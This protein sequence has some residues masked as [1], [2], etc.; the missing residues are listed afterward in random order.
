MSTVTELLPPPPQP[1]A[2]PSQRLAPVARLRAIAGDSLYRNS[3]M[4]MANTAAS[5]ILGAVFWLVAARRFTTAEVGI[6]LATLSTTMLLGTAS[7]LGLPNSVVRF[8]PRRPETSGQLTVTAAVLTSVTSAVLF[9]VAAGTPWA[10]PLLR[11]HPS[12][13]LVLLGL[14]VVVLTSAAMTMDSTFIAQRSAHLLLVKNI[15]GGVVKVVAVALLPGTGLVTLASAILLGIVVSGVVTLA[16]MARRLS[17]PLGFSMASLSGVWSFSLGNHA[18]MICGILPI[19]ATPLIVLSS[20]GADKAAFFGV[21]MMLMGMLTVI[22]STFSQSLFAE[23]SVAPDTRKRQIRRAARATYLLLLPAVAVVLVAAR[24]LLRAF[25]RSYAAGGTACLRW[26]ALGALVAGTNYLVDVIVNSRGHAGSYLFLNASNAFLVLACTA[27]AAPYG[28]AAVGVGWLVAQ[29]LSVVVALGYLLASRPIAVTTAGAAIDGGRGGARWT[30]NA[31]SGTIDLTDPPVPAPAPPRGRRLHFLDGLR[32]LAAAF[33][34]VSHSWSTVFPEGRTQRTRVEV[35]TSWMGLGHYA[36]SVFIVISGFSLGLVAWRNDLHWPGGMRAFFK[37]RFRRI[38]PAYWAAIA[39]GAGLGATLL[40]HKD[41]TLWDGAVPIRL[42]GVITHALLLQ[43]VHWAG[44]A[45]STA[46]WSLAV[47]WHIYL[48]FPL[49]LVFL[50][51]RPEAWLA[52]FVLFGGIAAYS[53]LATSTAFTRWLQN[54]HPSLYALFV[55]GLVAARAAGQTEQ[56]LARRRRERGLMVAT[57][58]GLVAAAAS[59]RHFDPVG[60]I[61]D[62]WFGPA[63]ALGIGRLSTGSWPSARRLLEWRPLVL[64]G[65]C[66]Y[67][68]YLIHS[69]IIESVWRVAVKPLGLQGFSALSAEVV[70]GLAASV[71]AAAA[72]YW[73]VERHFLSSGARTAIAPITDAPLPVQR[74][75]RTVEEPVPGPGSLGHAYAKR[76]NSLN[77]LRVFFAFLVIVG[78][79]GH[80]GFNRLGPHLG[81]MY[82]ADVAVDGFFVISGFL[83][84][85]SRLRSRSGASYL[86]KRA[87]R[88]LPGYWACLVVTAFGLAPLLYWRIHGTFAGFMAAGN[89]PASYVTHN[90]ILVQAQT[91]VAGVLPHAMVPYVLNGSLWTL[92]YECLAYLGLAALASVGL[93]RSR[94]RLLPVITVLCLVGLAWLTVDPAGFKATLHSPELLPRS[95]RLGAVFCAGASLRLW[96]DRVPVSGRIAALCAVVVVASSALTDWQI[97]GAVPF[98]YLVLWL[99]T[100]LRR[101]HAVGSRHDLSYGIYLYAWPI[102]QTLTSVGGARLGFGGYIAVTTAVAAGCAWLSWRFIEA[103]AIRL[104]SLR[105]RGHATPPLP[106]GEVAQ[107]WFRYAPALDGL[108]AVAIGCVLLTHAGV[109]RLLGASQGVTVF[110]VVSG[111]L[112]TSLLLFEHDKTGRIDRGAFYRRRFARLLPVF[113]LSLLV[114]AAYLLADGYSIGKIWGPTVASLAY[115]ANFFYAAGHFGA[116]PGNTFFR[117]IWSLSIEEQ[118]Y[119]V[120]PTAVVLALKTR[121]AERILASVAGIVAI[122]ALVERRLLVRSSYARINYSTDTRIDAIML[123][124]LL[125]IALRRPAVRAAIARRADLL[126]AAGALVLA[127]VVVQGAV[128][129]ADPGGY[130]AAAL[131]SALLVAALV[132]RP[133]GS[134]HRFFACRPLVH[135]GRLSY[136]MYLW[137]VLLLEVFVRVVGEKPAFTPLG[138]VWL[139]ATWALSWASYRWVEKP[140]RQRFRAR[141]PPVPEPTQH[142]APELVSQ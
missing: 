59:Y 104:K 24:L 68:L 116:E 11:G 49:L 137:N 52:P 108:R 89:P 32:G 131:A 35:L 79:S 72:F 17:R 61:N 33:V 8:L 9:A 13:R 102:Q 65:A 3:L 69:A 57:V 84:T 29:S 21:A 63:A 73:L 58:I 122:G 74:V 12:A 34:V 90:A 142:P 97:V 66:S 22:P 128:V 26:M 45:G 121:W 85:S 111:F 106:P 124:C 39:F 50:R 98:A 23:L 110:F 88:I 2:P 60:S 46:F 51:R 53:E 28:L 43:D 4:L 115:M 40:S 140:L 99:G 105:L 96:H 119:V 44:P 67:S 80:L 107:P 19:T 71:A 120:W 78:H 27:F 56:P 36:V 91:G 10:L 47:E 141:K 87:L 55:V 14:A 41:G 6:M 48:L 20:L 83:I 133:S 103:P 123:G 1:P 42:S 109:S 130:S 112:I 54:L 94:S 5:T 75:R 114:T 93:L 138:L 15:A 7:S 31:G 132:A 126:L 118:F 95:V 139:A 62:L 92:L 129:S 117:H 134:A 70:L 37:G 30:P 16:L 135:L 82:P 86:W 18:G 113:A 101:L 76:S 25:G 125:A 127:I 100:R 77:F 136:G 38:V 81:S 64:L